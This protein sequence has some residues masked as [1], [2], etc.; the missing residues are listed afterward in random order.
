MIRE[1]DVAGGWKYWNGRVGN[2]FNALLQGRWSRDFAFDSAACLAAAARGSSAS[3]LTSR[4]APRCGS[5]RQRVASSPA[6][7]GPSSTARLS[8]TVQPPASPAAARTAQSWTIRIRR[9]GL[10]IEFSAERDAVRTLEIAIPK[11]GPQQDA[12][13]PAYL[14]SRKRDPSP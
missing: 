13:T 7:S 4:D 3:T 9:M 8:E 1:A 6:Q 5:I 12:P 2:R 10:T 11:V 14:D